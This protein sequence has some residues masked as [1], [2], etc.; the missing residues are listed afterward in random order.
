MGCS[1]ISSRFIFKQLPAPLYLSQHPRNSL[2]YS[3]LLKLRTTLKLSLK[4]ED[5]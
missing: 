1:K 2:T 4:Q 5:Y 3:V